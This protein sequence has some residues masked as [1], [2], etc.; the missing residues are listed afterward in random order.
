MRRLSA[1]ER[2]IRGDKSAK[3]DGATYLNREWTPMNANF[4]YFISVHSCPF[5]VLVTNAGTT[6]RKL[7][8]QIFFCENSGLRTSSTDC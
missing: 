5:A 8:S 1:N 7:E 2:P 3:M 6:H 4:E